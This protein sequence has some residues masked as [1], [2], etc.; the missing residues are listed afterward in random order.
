[1]CTHGSLFSVALLY[2]VPRLHVSPCGVPPV[3]KKIEKRKNKLENRIDLVL[4]EWQQ[5]CSDIG[6]RK[7][8]NDGANFI[9]VICKQSN[10]HPLAGTRN[11]DEEREE[12]KSE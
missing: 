5:Q 9:F 7:A 2:V 12:R 3:R 8:V 11:G 6:M 1:L 4:Q 10:S